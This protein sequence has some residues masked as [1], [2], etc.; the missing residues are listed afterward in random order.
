MKMS[1]F[2][3]TTSIIAALLV[4]AASLFSAYF[5]PVDHPAFAFGIFSLLGLALTTAI[6]SLMAELEGGE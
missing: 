4:A 6:I 5:P 1:K 3:A 2:M